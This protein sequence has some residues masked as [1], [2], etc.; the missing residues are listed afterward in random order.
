MLPRTSYPPVHCPARSTFR[1][2][3][4]RNWQCVCVRNSFRRV[5][6][7]Q[8]ASSL[9]GASSRR[10]LNPH[11]AV[12][13]QSHEHTPD[14]FL[15]PPPFPSSTWKEL[16]IG[17]LHHNSTFTLQGSIAALELMDPK[18]DSGMKTESMLAPIKTLDDA[19]NRGLALETLKPAE[20]LGIMDDLVGALVSWLKGHSLVQTVFSCVYLHDVERIH[21]LSLKAFCVGLLKIVS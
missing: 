11:P 14:L 1:F 18:M 8:P 10:I 12:L 20:L 4:S 2:F 7:R 17:Q 15:P 21:D 9:V 3:S 13:S 19:V 16:E 5:K 6:A